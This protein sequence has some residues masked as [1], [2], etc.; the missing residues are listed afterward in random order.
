MVEISEEVKKLIEE[1]ALAF[2]TVDE[3]GNPHCIAVGDVKV[4][5]TDQLL[6]GDNYMIETIQNIKRNPKV[7]LAVWNRNWEEKCIGYEL[8]G[9][10]EY[11]T[12]GKWHEMVK[13]IH[14]GFP[15]KGAILVTINKIKKLA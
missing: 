8:R 10:A 2:A 13:E 6:V 1:N 9:V 12:S 11:F 7:A 3:N 4:V 14:K 5:S 15:A